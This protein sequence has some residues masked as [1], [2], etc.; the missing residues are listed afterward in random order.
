MGAGK[1][2][3]IAEVEKVYDDF[4]DEKLT[5]D[6]AIKTLIG[7]GFDKHEAEDEIKTIAFNRG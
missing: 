1:D 3:W 7:L 5:E 2:M 6:E 4:A